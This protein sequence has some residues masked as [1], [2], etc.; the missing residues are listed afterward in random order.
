[1]LGG[2]AGEQRGCREMAIDETD[3]EGT[4]VSAGRERKERGGGTGGG[5]QAGPAALLSMSCAS[6]P[7]GGTSHSERF[8]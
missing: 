2:Q 3:C 7:E 5:P 6:R 8:L 1:M 4:D